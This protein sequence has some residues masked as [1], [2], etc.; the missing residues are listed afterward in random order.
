MY[1]NAGQK[2]AFFLLTINCHIPDPSMRLAIHLQNQPKFQ[3]HFIENNLTVVLWV[4][5][6]LNF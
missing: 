3:W 4:F 2:P 6:S 5:F 1:I